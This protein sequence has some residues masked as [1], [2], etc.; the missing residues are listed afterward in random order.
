MNAVLVATMKYSDY[1]EGG[2]T[3]DI[4]LTG[5]SPPIKVWALKPSETV[6]EIVNFKFSCGSIH[7]PPDCLVSDKYCK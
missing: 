3:G 2:G 4:T 6:S 7:V 5:F 1:L